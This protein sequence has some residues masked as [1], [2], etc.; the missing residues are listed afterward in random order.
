[1]LEFFELTAWVL[2]WCPVDLNHFGEKTK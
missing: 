1:M 2:N